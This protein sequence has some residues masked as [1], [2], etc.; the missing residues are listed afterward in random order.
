MCFVLYVG[1]SKPVL[2][3][4]WRKNAP[5]LSVE[6]LTERERPITANFSKPEVQYVGSTSR[7]GCDFPHVIFQNG[8]WPWYE[9][10]NEDELN[11]ERKKTEQQNREC[12]ASLLRQTGETSVELYGVW[13]GDF[14]TPPAI[15]EEVHLAAILD[16]S[17]R[18]KEQ[19]FYNVLLT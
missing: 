8:G 15:R 1:T 19:G 9:D 2:R 3:K 14:R 16:P 4:E 5:D 10:Q 12:L 7:C 6:A 13:D 17:F 18:F 11:R